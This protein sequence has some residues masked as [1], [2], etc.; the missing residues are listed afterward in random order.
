AYDVREIEFVREKAAEHGLL[1]VRDDAAIDSWVQQAID[2]NPQAAAD[3]RAGKEAA[4]GRIVGAAAKLAAGKADAAQL[5]ERIMAK[6]G[7]G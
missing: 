3:V 1:L 7:R 2:A 4:A 6:L 5:R